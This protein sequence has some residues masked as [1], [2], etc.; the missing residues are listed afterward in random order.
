MEKMILPTLTKVQCSLCGKT[1]YSVRYIPSNVCPDCCITKNED[2][3][4]L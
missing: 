1:F 4:I 3:E 2:K